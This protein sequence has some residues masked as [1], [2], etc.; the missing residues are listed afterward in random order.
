MPRPRLQ[1]LIFE[2]TQACDHTCTY[3][4]N[5][6]NHPQSFQ[7]QRASGKI[8]DLRPLLAHVL[9]QVDC[10]LV[11]LT[12]GEP[13]LRPDLPEIVSFLA[14]RDIR[15]NLI[16]N[17]HR[18]TETVTADLIE[19]GVTLFEL[20]LLSFRRATHDALS[21]SVGAFDAVL[22][23]LAHIR[24]HRG[25]AVTVFVATR[26]NIADLHDTLKLAFAF[27]VRGVMF[28]RFNPGGRGA[29]AIDTL[30]PGVDEI[31]NAL[32]IAEAASQE[33]HLPVSCSI[34]IQPCL[35]DISNYPHLGFGFCAAGSSRAYYTL[36][37]DGNVRPCNHTPTIL[38][39]VWREPFADIIAPGRLASFVAAVPPFCAPCSRK[40]ECQGGCKASA[41]VCYG[42][43]SA[44]DP[45][46]HRNRE[47][48]TIFS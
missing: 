8:T 25:Q 48:A 35:I 38:G 5:Y 36:D 29:A 23:A 43:L 46:L 26:H 22:A 16:T 6:W 17:G 1:T 45:F 39:N 41:Q 40:D 28:N 3:C 14:G 10:N 2:I 13:L 47:A 12:G 15:V 30:L 7:K 19:R 31:R 24:Y 34:P 20:P 21:S 42:D 9:D 11:T 44:E 4:Y 27:G 18:L 37:I 32:A 33:Y